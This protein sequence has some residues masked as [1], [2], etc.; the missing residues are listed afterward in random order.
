MM[1][2]P[3][4]WRGR[5]RSTSRPGTRIRRWASRPAAQ[6]ASCV[7]PRLNALAHRARLAQ[8]RREIAREL[9]AQSERVV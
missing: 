1:P 3:A 9:A 8:T 4:P 5:L 2:K 6:V 7:V